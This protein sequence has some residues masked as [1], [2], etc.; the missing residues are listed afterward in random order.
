MHLKLGG[1]AY[2]I[3]TF[4]VGTPTYCDS[5]D[6]NTSRG[7]I[8]GAPGQGGSA[9]GNAGIGGQAGQVLDCSFN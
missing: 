7:G 5:A 4:G 3:Y 9:L 2:G 1:N 8:G 6:A